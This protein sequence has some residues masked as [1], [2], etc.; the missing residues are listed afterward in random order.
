MINVTRVL[1]LT[2]SGALNDNKASYTEKGR[3]SFGTLNHS[4]VLLSIMRCAGNGVTYHRPLC[5]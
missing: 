1:L 2:A 4:S 5:I 3:G